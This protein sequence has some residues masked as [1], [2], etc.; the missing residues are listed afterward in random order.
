VA[1]IYAQYMKNISIE[2]LCR[3]ERSCQNFLYQ[4]YWNL[5]HRCY[6]RCNTV[7]VQFNNSK[8]K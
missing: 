7:V 8:K 2:P 1:H 6:T 4:R 5:H 3:S